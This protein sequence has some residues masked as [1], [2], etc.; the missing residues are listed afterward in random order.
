MNGKI[1]ING[2]IVEYRQ[3]NYSLPSWITRVE[4]RTDNKEFK[5]MKNDSTIPNQDDLFKLA[6]K[7]L[8][9]F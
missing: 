5:I 8:K 4:M 9:K 6:K 2:K 1:K 3:T 7:Y